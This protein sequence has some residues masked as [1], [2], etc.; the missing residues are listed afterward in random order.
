MELEASHRLISNHG[1]LFYQ[2]CC[3]RDN[4]LLL[5]TPIVTDNSL[6][7]D[8]MN[9]FSC[10][11]LLS[12]GYIF[13][14]IHV[15][16]LYTIYRVFRIQNNKSI[17]LFFQSDCK[18]NTVLLLD[19]IWLCTSTHSVLPSQFH[20]YS[21]SIYIDTC[22][23]NTQEGNKYRSGPPYTLQHTDIPFS[24]SVVKGCMETVLF[25]IF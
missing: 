24:D 20:C 6:Y 14:Y 17:T 15:Y 18:Y 8:L 13:D 3:F 2:G 11:L 19:L 9:W 23:V 16:S 1:S 12:V 25:Y 21:E 5:A 22:L 7:I 4:I 10:L